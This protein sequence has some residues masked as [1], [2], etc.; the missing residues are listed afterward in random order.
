MLEMDDGSVDRHIVQ[1]V[2]KGPSDAAWRWTGQNPVVKLEIL[3]ASGFKYHADFTLADVTF[4]ETGPVSITFF[5]NGHE[6]GTV[7][8]DTSGSKVFEAPVPPSWL[9]PGAE[10]T[11]SALIDKV[12]ISKQDG[13][14]LGFILSRI[15]LV[16]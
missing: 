2:S 4:R 12:Y 7:R 15:G 9:H 6:L 8:Y 13:A 5:V 11:L 3:G 16:H 14:K 10:N 1:D